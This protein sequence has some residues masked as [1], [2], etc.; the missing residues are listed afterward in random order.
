MHGGRCEAVILKY[1]LRDQRKSFRTSSEGLFFRRRAADDLKVGA[2]A[3]YLW[4]L[5]PHALVK[6]SQTFRNPLGRITR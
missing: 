5:Q 2:N 3:V 4:N 1:S 6:R